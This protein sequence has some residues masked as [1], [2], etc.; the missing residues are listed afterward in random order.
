MRSLLLGFSTPRVD[1]FFGYDYGT[2]RRGR[3]I[4]SLNVLRGP[5]DY[6]FPL[7]STGI[8]H[9]LNT[10]IYCDLV[11]STQLG[12]VTAQHLGIFPRQKT[13]HKTIKTKHMRFVPVAVR[14]FTS[15]SVQFRT[16]STGELL[17]FD[18]HEPELIR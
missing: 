12:N 6:L 16:A 17:R 4:I 7:P 10:I 1:R 13:W 2:S 3:Y 9:L 15:V 11:E 18:Q 14:D 8:N 5:A